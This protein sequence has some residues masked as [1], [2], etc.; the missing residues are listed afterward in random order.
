MSTDKNA[1]FFKLIKAG[2]W[3]QELVLFSLGKTDLEEVYRM[4]TSQSVVGLIASGLEHAVGAKAP[5]L[6]VLP[7]MGRV[8]QIEQ[9]NIEMNRF[10]AKLIRT[11]NARGIK[12][13]LVKGQG[14][15]QCYERPLW[16]SAGDIDLLL[17]IDNYKEA[18]N[19]LVEEAS[20]IDLENPIT[21]HQAL[22]IEQWV[23]ELHG[24]LH[25]GLSSKMD[26]IL[27]DIQDVTIRKWQVRVWENDGV[28]VILPDV[29]NDVIFIFTHILKHFYKGGI[30]L[31]QICDWCRLL[32]T[33]REEIDVT[34]LENR[35]RRIG[36]KSEWK[37][38]GAFAVH[39]L[40]MPVEAMPLL[41]ETDMVS[42]SQL[43]RKADRICSFILEVG[44]F[45]H[46]RDTS[47]YS[48]YPFLIRKA[49]SMGQRIGDLIRH[50][51]IF[52]LNS[53]RFFPN[54]MFN[55]LKS[56]VKGGG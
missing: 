43:K 44:N 28:A 52:P 4:A 55:G 30:G 5:K 40:G 2:L 47:Y 18:K 37:A 53:L 25:C 38:F 39:Y 51:R 11:L 23:I 21:M 35:L 1:L 24:T 41:C 13:L 15:A 20:S 19:L 45:G 36:L 46:N 56:V 14:I 8:L 12:A 26:R 42:N 31:R 54:I 32:W 9:R 17:D 6:S 7:F 16:R 33:Y 34:L 27:D 3:E 29:N 48:K 49:I 50:A 22:T 10:V